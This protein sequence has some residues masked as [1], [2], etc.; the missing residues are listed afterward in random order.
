M[1][2]IYSILNYSQLFWLS[3][4][5]TASMYS[6]GFAITFLHKCVLN[7]F[8][9][10]AHLLMKTTVELLLIIISDFKEVK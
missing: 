3:A 9:M 4:I 1:I 7:E 6:I 5:N 8:E 2:Y 10:M